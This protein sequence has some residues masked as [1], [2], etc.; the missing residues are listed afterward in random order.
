MRLKKIKIK[1]QETSSLKKELTLALSGEQ[2]KIQPS[3]EVILN[4]VEAFSRIFTKSRIEILFFLAKN[5]PVSIYELAKMLQK[6]FKNV[7]SDVNVLSEI[8]LISLEKSNS[9]RGSLIPK[10]KYSGIEL[11]FAA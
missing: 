9:L 3:N 1:I 4:S 6:D 8:G 10:A 11:S 5:H 7:H 2:H